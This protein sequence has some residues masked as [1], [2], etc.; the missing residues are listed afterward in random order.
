MNSQC[1][2]AK[3]HI[4][5]GKAINEEDIDFTLIGTRIKTQREKLELTQEAL[6]ELMGMSKQAISKFEQH[7]HKYV[8][9][10]PILTIS[11]FAKALNC[12][13]EYL[14]GD[15]EHPCQ[16]LLTWKGEKIYP[17]SLTYLSHDQQELIKKEY[18][19]NKDNGE[20]PN[21]RTSKSLDLS[22]E[23]PSAE[24]IFTENHLYFSNHKTN[25]AFQLETPFGK[26]DATVKEI[27]DPNFSWNFPSLTTQFSPSGKKL[28]QNGQDFIQLCNII[29]LIQQD[30]NL[31]SCLQNFVNILL[32]SSV[33]TTANEHI[34]IHSFIGHYTNYK[35]HPKLFDTF[36]KTIQSLPI[37][38]LN[39]VEEFLLNLQKDIHQ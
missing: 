14:R 24:L 8:R 30:P 7:T 20:F 27:V 13:I 28:D 33:S 17:D 4:I 36:A 16:I 21:N 37:K 23:T 32:K 9:K 19:Q 22:Q 2:F 6:G 34:H 10:D 12:T 26:S 11:K 25:N 15:V 31:F 29:L 3:T 39:Q 35:E 38:K 5:V 1:H 18:N